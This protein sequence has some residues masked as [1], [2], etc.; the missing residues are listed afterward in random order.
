MGTSW[1]ERWATVSRYSYLSATALLSQPFRGGAGVRLRT[2][3]L[4]ACVRGTLPGPAAAQSD[5]PPLRLCRLSG[6]ISFDGKVNEAAWD[7]GA[8]LPLTMYTPNWGGKLTE[9]TELRVAYDDKYLYV[10]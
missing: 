9:R 2:V 5:E 7:A 4:V 3:L 1:G 8:P 6:P 10:A